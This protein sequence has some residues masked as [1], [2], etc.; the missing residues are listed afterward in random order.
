MMRHLM[1]PRIAVTGVRTPTPRK[2]SALVILLSALAGTGCGKA[3]EK[4]A[5][6]DLEAQRVQAIQRD[7]DGFWIHYGVDRGGR[8]QDVKPTFFFQGDPDGNLFTHNVMIVSGPD[9]RAKR[10]VLE[11]RPLGQVLRQEAFRGRIEGASEWT[12][13]WEKKGLST[14][15]FMSVHSRV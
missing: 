15:Y 10:V 2:V 3:P 13:A 5:F 12:T 7:L 6:T 8:V 14:R 11:A 9:L 4:V 1:Y